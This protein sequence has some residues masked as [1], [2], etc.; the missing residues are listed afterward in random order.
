MVSPRRMSRMGAEILAV[1][2]AWRVQ[3]AN[4]LR[5]RILTVPV[6]VIVVAHVPGL[7]GALSF[8]AIR[9]QD[10]ALN[11]FPA[12]GVDRV[13]NVGM[14]LGAALGI[15]KGPILVQSLA[16]LVAK[17]GPQVVFGTALAAAISQ[18]TAGHCNETILG[19]FDN[20]EVANDKCIIEGH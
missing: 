12:C 18:L 4:D 17:A 11:N 13:G 19:A 6:Q 20:L 16:A 9:F 3:F 14:E 5:K 15:T 10:R 7:L 8:F 2:T 1:P